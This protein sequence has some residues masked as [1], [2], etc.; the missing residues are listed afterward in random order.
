MKQMYTRKSKNVLFCFLNVAVLFFSGMNRSLAQSAEYA[1]A[2][3]P[4]LLLSFSGEVDASDIQLDW[5]MENET[6]SK[7][8]VVEHS[9]D[10]SDFDSIGVVTALNNAH[11]S[12]YIYTDRLAQ[13]GSNYYRLRQVDNDDVSRYSKVITLNYTVVSDKVQVFPNPAVAVLNY[14]IT[15][16]G[17]DQALVQVFNLAGV[18]VST[19][20]HSLVA[21]ENQQSIAIGGLRSGSYFL[22][23]SSR[24][25]ASQHVQEFVKL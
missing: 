4:S 17:A 20:Q 23:I 22:K 10:G 11:Q 18:V 5:V 19:Q 15:S 7:W 24:L 1:S 16:A 12:N 25:G 3:T 8:F 14:S 6:N 9:V 2:I 21:G 13:S